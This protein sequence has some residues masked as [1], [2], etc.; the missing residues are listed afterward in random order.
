MLS[1]CFCLI[2][3]FFTLP[4]YLTWFVASFSCLMFTCSIFPLV[5]CLCLAFLL[6]L[7]LGCFM[8]SAL[9]STQQGD[10]PSWFMWLT[11]LV[12]ALCPLTV[13][14]IGLVTLVVCL[15]R[16]WLCLIIPGLLLIFWHVVQKYGCP[17]SCFLSSKLN[18]KTIWSLR[19]T[20]FW[21]LRPKRCRTVQEL[22]CL[23][24]VWHTFGDST[25]MILDLTLI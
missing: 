16:S 17:P 7:V 3:A 21:R 9:V 15:K 4:S 8:L 23:S 5:F 6:C 22:W 20:R 19:T 24:T 10:P 12:T 2:V 11:R 14:T 13:S 25:K 1:F 18:C